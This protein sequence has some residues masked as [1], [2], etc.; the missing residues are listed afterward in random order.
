MRLLFLCNHYPPRHI[1]GYEELCQDVAIG[2]RRRGHQVTVLTSRPRPGLGLGAAEDTG[3]EG[4][5]G[6][7]PQVIRTLETEVA[8]GD[9]L[10]T[11][12]LILGREGRAARN[13]H[14]LA[15]ALA[16]V[17]SDAAV[18]WALWNL[19]PGIAAGL[20]AAL[21]QR[22]LYYVADYWPTLPDAVTQHLA[23]PSR[24]PVSRLAKRLLAAGLA[25]PRR[26]LSDGL[27]MAEVACVSQAVLDALRSAGVSMGR[28]EVIHNGI[29]PAQ[30]QP[31]DHRPDPP[32]L[33]LLLAGRLAEDKGVFTAVEALAL[34]RS[35]GHD[36]R[37]SL[38]GAA[39]P[40]VEA[41]LGQAID[42]LGL[43]DRVRR[44]GRMPRERVPAMI[45]EHHVLLVPSLWPD[46]LPRSAQEGMATGLA[47]VASRIGGLPELITHDESGLLVSPG[48]PVALAQAI[49]RLAADPALRQRLADAGRRRIGDAFEIRRTVEAVES[50]LQSMVGDPDLGIPPR[51]MP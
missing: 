42:R 14:R 46:P 2:L 4:D 32:P 35:A 40:A 44:L 45:A 51:M 41:A 27:R 12:R 3:A 7:E 18:V 34:A 10:A 22:V 5:L 49:G 11:P 33:R 47:V 13:R 29:D 24:R 26:R 16:R 37:L 48:D 30:F 23:A 20:E 28:A 43:Q 15:E 50:R 25:R 9:P 1:G 21:G 17:Q 36:V 38:A 39:D 19:S 31:A 6:E 8:V